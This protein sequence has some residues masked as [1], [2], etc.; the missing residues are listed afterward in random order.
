MIRQ[1]MKNLTSSHFIGPAEPGCEGLSRVVSLLLVSEV[2]SPRLHFLIAHFWFLIFF[3]SFLLC[4]F[5]FLCVYEREF[6]FDQF[7]EEDISYQSCL[8]P[9][10]VFGEFSESVDAISCFSVGN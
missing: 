1:A 5:R 8:R 2:V 7:S 9:F 3:S 6:S 10:S 4:S